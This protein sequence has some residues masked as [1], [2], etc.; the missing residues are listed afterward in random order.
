MYKKNS[1][2]EVCRHDTMYYLRSASTKNRNFSY[3]IGSII[4]L[5]SSSIKSCIK[6]CTRVAVFCVYF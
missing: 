6:S 4:E 3:L 5:Q 1:H 2:S